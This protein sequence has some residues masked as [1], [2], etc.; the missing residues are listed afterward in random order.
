MNV[1]P[2]AAQASGSAAPAPGT[3]DGRV[4]TP[5]GAGLAGAL[6]TLEPGAYTAQVSGVPVS[7]ITAIG[8]LERKRTAT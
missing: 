4:T 5:D 6:V 2:A 7:G 8:S 1:M 3:I